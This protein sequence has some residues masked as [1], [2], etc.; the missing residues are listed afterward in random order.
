MSTLVVRLGAMGDILHTL[1]AVEALPGRVSW[2]LDPK[3]RPLLAGHPKIDE[4][5][6]FDRRSWASV[7]GAVRRMRARRFETAFD[8][9][10]L[11]KSALVARL[12][13]ARRVVGHQK[14]NLREPLARLLYG[15]TRPAPAV[16]VVDKQ[17]QLAGVTLGG[18][19]WL[20]PG[21]PEGDLPDT[22]FV[23]ASPFAG[24]RSKQWPL[25]N[26]A[27]LAR[28]VPL[29]LNVAPGDVD[30]V[31]HLRGVIVHVSSLA[32][33][34]DATR[35]AAAVVGLDSG[36]LH[37]AAALRK[38]GVA[39]FGPTDPRR[40]GP[41]GDTIRVL[42]SPTATTSYR[43]GDQIDP[44]MRQITPDAVHA[45]LATLLVS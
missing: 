16:H 32:G 26:W 4:L 6:P 7:R 5:I 34:I 10:G 35:R 21:E 8:F 29:V 18:P 12:S 24:W 33:L 13:G 31:R 20:P 42:R 44:A 27:E 25:E 45:E 9:Q 28:R 11:I 36:P 14:E 2:V 15:E 3:W 43:R 38:P 39:L 1:P 40:N 30:T 19:V 22:P 41:Y 23:L 37:L 17:A